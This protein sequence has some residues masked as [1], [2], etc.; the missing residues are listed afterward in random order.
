[1][2]SPR[3]FVEIEVKSVL[4]RVTGMP[5]RW[6]INPY[7]GCSHG[8]PFCLS[9]DTPILMADGTTRSL[10]EIR[11]GDQIYGTVPHGRY[12]RYARTFVL[13]HWSVE[14]PAYRITLDHGTQLVASGDHRFLTGRGWKFV[15]RAQQGTMRRPHLTKNSKLMGTGKFAPSPQR[16]TDYKRGY[17]CGLI[18]GDGFLGFYEYEQEG[19]MRG[20]RYQFRLELTDGEALERA[21]EYLLDFAIS[22]RRYVLQRAGAGVRRVEAIGA[23]SRSCVEGIEKVVRRA[24]REE[25]REAGFRQTAGAT[26]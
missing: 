9:G 21:Q 1:M 10:E 6:S 11:I 18:R 16:T 12:R 14:K 20:N 8:C 2:I 25:L 24:V 7:R 4:N 13:A 23:Q 17:L 19:R 26:R 3:E 5:F 22:T 15:T